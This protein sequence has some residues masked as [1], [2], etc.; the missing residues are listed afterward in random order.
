MPRASHFVEAYAQDDEIAAAIG[1]P[2][3][4]RAERMSEWTPE[5][6][7]LADIFDRLGTL[8]SVLMQVNGNKA[9]HLSTFPRPITATQRL[10]AADRR[11][12]HDSLSARLYPDRG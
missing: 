8:V 1:L 7:V 4:K 3:A 6:E 9:P 11:Q 12:K 5:R 2:N 10:I